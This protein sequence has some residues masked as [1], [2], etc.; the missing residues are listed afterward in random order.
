[1]CMDQYGYKKLILRI[2][3]KQP[4]LVHKLD[5]RKKMVQYKQK[6]CIQI[7]SHSSAMLKC[8]SFVYIKFQNG[9]CRLTQ[10]SQQQNSS[11]ERRCNAFVEYLFRSL[12]IS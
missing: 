9:D 5:L 6:H 1:M 12:V 7:Y 2:L 3:Y 10:F 4:N 8:D 11:N